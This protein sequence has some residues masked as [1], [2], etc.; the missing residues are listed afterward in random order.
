MIGV[1]IAG[2]IIGA[3][4]SQVI[5]LA[6]SHFADKRDDDRRTAAD[7]RKRVDDKLERLEGAVFGSPS[8]Y[9]DYAQMKGLKKQVKDIELRIGELEEKASKPS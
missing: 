1:F 6:I 9:P 3:I 2:A 8:Y 4:I 5:A 7:A